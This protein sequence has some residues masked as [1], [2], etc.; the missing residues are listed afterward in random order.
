ML[1]PKTLNEFYYENDLDCDLMLLECPG[2]IRASRSTL[3]KGG[4]KMCESGL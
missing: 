4:Q 1:D 3:L 2:P